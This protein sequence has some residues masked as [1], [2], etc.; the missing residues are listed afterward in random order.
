MNHIQ[1]HKLR[2]GFIIAT[3]VM[4]VVALLFIMRN[5]EKTYVDKRISIILISKRLDV[6]SDFWSSVFE[7]ANIAASD[8][9]IDLTII[10]PESET[11]YETQ[12]EMIEEAIAMKP[13]AIA[14][15]PSSYT[16]TVLYAKKIEDAGIKLILMDSVMEKDM[17]QCVVATDN[18]EGGFKMG[19]YMKQYVDETS[20]IGIVSHIKGASTAIDREQGVRAGLGKYEKRIADVVYSDSNNDKAYEVTVQMME[21]HP[22][23]DIIIGLNEDS[24]VGAA[25]AV[26]ALGLSNQIRMIGFDSSLE[27]VQLLEEGVFDAIVVQK[28]LNMGYLGIKMSYQAVINKAIPKKVDSGSVL[29]TDEFIYTKENEKLLFPFKEEN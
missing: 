7:G 24:T 29:I 9:D 28:P 10:G 12:G 11:D 1:H 14:L 16:M 6:G 26:K 2:K 23:M 20:V 17:G 21:A 13:D 3:V 5:Y 8:Y 15:A 4:A 19:S 22:D 25:R 18:Y 27:Q